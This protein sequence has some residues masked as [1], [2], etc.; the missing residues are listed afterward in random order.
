VADLAQIYNRV[1][2]QVYHQ[3]HDVD[4]ALQ[5]AKKAVEDFNAATK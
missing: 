4:T 3:T 1:F 5:K 2:A